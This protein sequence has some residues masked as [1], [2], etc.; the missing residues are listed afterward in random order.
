[1]TKPFTSN[2]LYL[3][4]NWYQSDLDHYGIFTT[5]EKAKKFVEK[6]GGEIKPLNVDDEV[7]EPE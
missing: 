5:Q 7:E 6:H 1:M 3:V 4:F 2:Q